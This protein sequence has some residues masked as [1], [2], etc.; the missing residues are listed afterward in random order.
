MYKPNFLIFG[1]APMKHCCVSLT[2][3]KVFISDFLSVRN[4]ANKFSSSGFGSSL[5][6]EFHNFFKDLKN[7]LRI[8]R[9]F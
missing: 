5:G 1:I 8:A 7:I 9:I 2:K 4:F 3:I 6:V